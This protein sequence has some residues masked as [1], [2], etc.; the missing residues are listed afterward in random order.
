MAFILK[1][2]GSPSSPY[3]AHMCRRAQAAHPSS[4]ICSVWQRGV[5]DTRKPKK[6]IECT[7]YAY[8]FELNVCEARW[9][10]TYEPVTGF[11]SAVYVLSG[12]RHQQTVNDTWHICHDKLETI[13]NEPKKRKK[14]KHEQQRQ[15]HHPSPEPPIIIIDAFFR[16]WNPIR[17]A[18]W[19]EHQCILVFCWRKPTFLSFF[20]YFLLDFFFASW[21]VG[22]SVFH[23]IPGFHKFLC[24]HKF[25]PK[26][27]SIRSVVVTL[28]T[29]FP[30]HL[31]ITSP[32]LFS[33]LLHAK[34]LCES[35]W[36]TWAR[37]RGVA[38]SNI[39]CKVFLLP[40]VS[41]IFDSFVHIKNK[42]GR[43][44]WRTIVLLLLLFLCLSY[45][46]L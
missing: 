23:R 12:C 5:V 13:I 6:P 4:G 16:L 41:F 28:R 34:L 36:R 7:R 22:V 30:M 9:A 26:T 1:R 31:H 35:Q 3:T 21:H 29:Y 19:T 15:Q 40:F 11:A 45:L 18:T 14:G 42:H 17:R 24:I 8:L 37:C 2:T 20:S 46:A 38:F 39:R 32:L 43:R 10:T 33:E 25:W 44:W 27:F